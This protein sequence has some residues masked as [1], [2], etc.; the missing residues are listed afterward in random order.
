M[1]EVKVGASQNQQGASPAIRWPA[2]KL[3]RPCAT[4][5]S[6]GTRAKTEAVL[7][8]RARIA[9]AVSC[10]PAFKYGAPGMVRKVPA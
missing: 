8:S 10:A 1:H 7:R 2:L 9:G 3:E 6:L 4:A 5:L